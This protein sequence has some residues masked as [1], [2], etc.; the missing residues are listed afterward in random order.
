MSI[1]NLI[2]TNVDLYLPREP[3]ESDQNNGNHVQ[4]NAK[5]E[6]NECSVCLTTI[7]KD[8]NN[9]KKTVCNH[10]FHKTCLN[11]WLTCKNTCPLCRNIQ[12]FIPPFKLIMKVAITEAAWGFVRLIPF[13]VALA[14]QTNSPFLLTIKVTCIFQACFACVAKLTFTYGNPENKVKIFR[15]LRTAGVICQILIWRHYNIIQ[16]LGT[17]VASCFVLPSIDLTMKQWDVVDLDE[18]YQRN[19]FDTCPLIPNI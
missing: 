18:L 11:H 2:A 16:T 13:S 1:P 15:L 17:I 5:G 14:M 3:I 7:E 8:D 4:N 10:L 19:F 6:E 9:R 12:P